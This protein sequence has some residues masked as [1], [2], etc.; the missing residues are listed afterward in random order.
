ML[1]NVH[2][3]IIE[4]NVDEAAVGAAADE[5]GPGGDGV[6]RAGGQQLATMKHHNVALGAIAD[7]RSRP[8]IA[9]I[10]TVRRDERGVY[11]DGRVAH[12]TAA[13]G[14]AGGLQSLLL[15]LRPAHVIDKG[16]II[17]PPKVSAIDGRESA[18]VLGGDA[19]ERLKRRRRGG[20]GGQEREAALREICTHYVECHRPHFAKRSFADALG[21]S[22]S[23]I[24]RNGTLVQC[25]ASPS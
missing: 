8:C 25:C 16:G 11:D 14:G 13:V 9:G 5:V 15:T 20:D 1:P 21:S 6:R 7:Q 24:R 23:R 3:E 19:G 22:P 18:W 4:R 2:V 12:P 17:D 10:L